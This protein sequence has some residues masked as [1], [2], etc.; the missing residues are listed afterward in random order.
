MGS[1]N[2][3]RVIL[4]DDLG[5][6]S[7]TA[8]KHSVHSTQTP[9]HLG[10]S[11]HLINGDGQ[12]LVTQRAA[13][14]H[15]WPGVWTNACCGHPQIGETLRMAVQRRLHDE[16]GVSA[17]RMSLA[18]SDFTYRA[19]MPNGV[20][21]H[22]VCP[23][24][25]AE[26]DGEPMLN[27]DEVGDARWVRWE[28]LTE[29]ARSR[30]ESL[31]PW[32]VAQIARLS[33]LTPSLRAWIGRSVCEVALDTP[34]GGGPA[35]DRSAIRVDPSSL[36]DIGPAVDRF[37][38]IRRE[39]DDVLETFIAD[40]TAE[41]VAIDPALGTIAREIEALVASGGKRLRPAFVEWGHRASG[42]DHDPS[43][44]FVA[45]AVEM[46]HTFAL[47]HDDVMDR[48][49]T[50]RGRPSAHQALAVAHRDQRLAGDSAWF[51]ASAAILAG[52]LAF[53]WSD[54]LLDMASIRTDAIGDVRRVFTDLRVEV[55]AGQYLDLRLEGLETATDED[56]NRVALLK[57]G[58][59]TITRPLELGLALSNHPDE[60]LAAQLRAYGDALGLA[61]QLRDDILGLFGDPKRTGK[62][63]F[64]DLRSGKRTVLML[65]ALALCTP[66]QHA[67]MMSLLGTPD[68]DLD[69]A[70]RCREIVA[71]SG[72]LA[73]VETRLR[74]LHATA[75]EALTDVP[76]PA[77][78]ALNSLAADVVQ[79]DG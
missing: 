78:S 75:V 48:S 43:L 44:T 77:R 13:T 10:F 67:T 19:V 65:R 62:D 32:S 41:L 23:V 9:L 30:P 60:R 51:G 64:D 34:F 68:V 74:N 70:E 20:T 22:E 57:S 56:A 61:F 8:P 52:D 59:Y 55:M 45:A 49:A 37:E 72:A 35:G 46:L 24:V 31:S 14:K 54:Q 21:E 42:A 4:L 38:P 40:R 2:S 15:T 47:L 63:S 17:S 27:P 18:L 3:E 53:V 50:R 39:V 69:D 66:V 28:E 12:V 58:R 11:C 73:S 7:G 16:L 79:R 5:R 29:R 71:Q 36:A 1:Q 25:I 26:I 33:S 76:E 6:P